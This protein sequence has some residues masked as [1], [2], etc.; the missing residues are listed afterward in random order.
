MNPKLSIGLPIYN[1]IRYVEKTLD[2]ILSQSF[3]F[4]ELVI[5][6]NHSSDGTFEL[7]KKYS[8]KDKRIKLFRNEKNLGLVE[9]YNKAFNLSSGDYF[10]WIGAHALYDKN[11]FK[12]LINI[13]QENSKISLVFS[14]IAKIDKENNL[15]DKEKN[16]GF[17]LK[18]SK[19][20]D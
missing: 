19:L 12:L 14:N 16:I 6:D 4:Y 15:L 5:V 9:N 7:L 1:E 18:Y 17:M 10:S 11:Y 2:S 8:E 13:F 20:V 3:H